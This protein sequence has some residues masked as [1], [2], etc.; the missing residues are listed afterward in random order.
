MEWVTYYKD[1]HLS[2]A[3]KVTEL[4]KV[5]NIY[6]QKNENKNIAY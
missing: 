1:R 5:L 6:L 3:S 2:V 4:Q